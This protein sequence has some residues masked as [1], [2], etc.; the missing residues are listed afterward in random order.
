MDAGVLAAITTSGAAFLVAGVSLWSN[1]RT[2]AQGD[3]TAL[4][5]AELQTHAGAKQAREQALLQFAM[6]ARLKLLTEEISAAIG[7]AQQLDN[8]ERFLIGILQ[9]LS[10]GDRSVPDYQPFVDTIGKARQHALLLPVE[11][12]TAVELASQKFGTSYHEIINMMLESPTKD[13]GRLSAIAEK[14]RATGQ[15]VRRAIDGWRAALVGRFDQLLDQA[16]L[17]IGSGIPTSSPEFAIDDSL[18]VGSAEQPPTIDPED[19]E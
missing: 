6:Q 3:K 19:S 2:R 16:G 12:S 10:L 8:A 11:L 4:K 15:K 18:P 1:H 9:A 5:V 7:T 14:I 17:P 13:D